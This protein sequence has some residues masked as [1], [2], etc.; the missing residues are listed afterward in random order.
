MV[1]SQ[2]PRLKRPAAR[3]GPS[4]I[5]VSVQ[6]KFASQNPRHGHPDPKNRNQQFTNPSRHRLIAFNN[7]RPRATTSGNSAIMHHTCISISTRLHFAH[8]VQFRVIT[9]PFA[10]AHTL[11][12][13]DILGSPLH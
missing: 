2:R 7:V 9:D 6:G 12:T 8:L 10:Y 4:A 1:L 5:G 11:H 13:Y 3:L